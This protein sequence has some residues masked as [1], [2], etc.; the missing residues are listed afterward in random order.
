MA[1]VQRAFPVA[2]S[3]MSVSAVQWLPGALSAMLPFFAL[4]QS[5]NPGTLY[6]RGDDP[7][8]YGIMYSKYSVHPP[9]TPTRAG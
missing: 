5:T 3:K 6:L 1:T 2:K 7:N 9:I 8:L 4:N